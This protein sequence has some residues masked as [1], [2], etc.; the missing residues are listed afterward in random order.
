MCGSG[1]K[2]SA[3]PIWQH[4]KDVA[5]PLRVL[6]LLGDA[7]EAPAERAERGVRAGCPGWPPATAGGT[8]TGASR[9]DLA[10]TLLLR[11]GPNAALFAL[12][13]TRS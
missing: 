1:I 4:Y 9:G 11:A 8:L 10:P 2:R 7:G 13:S 5:A 3:R 6:R 12:S